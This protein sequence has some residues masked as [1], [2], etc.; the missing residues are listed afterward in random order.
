MK[1]VT[2]RNVA[3]F[4]AGLLIGIMGVL[5]SWPAHIVVGSELVMLKESV[6]KVFILNAVGDLK[7]YDR[8][9]LTGLSWYW[10]KLNA[11]QYNKTNGVNV[12][13]YGVEALRR[14]DQ[15]EACKIAQVAFDRLQ[16]KYHWEGSHKLLCPLRTMLTRDL[17]AK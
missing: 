3:T 6:G 5:F 12:S 17:P 10:T 7:G 11:L 13:Q 15:V 1:I 16:E 14:M 9:E 2:R 8:D 4:F